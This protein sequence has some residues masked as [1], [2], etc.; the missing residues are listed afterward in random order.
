MLL[1]NVVVS[2]F[3]GIAI[4]IVSQ[5]VSSMRSQIS[6]LETENVRL[7]DEVERL[8]QDNAVLRAR[9]AA[10]GR[11]AAGG[12]A[13]FLLGTIRKMLLRCAPADSDE[14]VRALFIDER[15]QPWRDLVHEA[16]NRY[17]RV[18]MLLNT[19]YDRF[20]DEGNNALCLFLYVLS[21]HIAHGD[22]CKRSLRGMA[23]ILSAELRE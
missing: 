19:L 11:D 2:L 3:L 13:R 5:T 8:R 18:N 4:A 16:P 23:E 17:E 15:L 9:I 21:E 22:E 10:M 14:S 1:I 6:D 12:G 20:D 7:H